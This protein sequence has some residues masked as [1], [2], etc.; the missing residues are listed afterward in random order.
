MAECEVFKKVIDREKYQIGSQLW[1][2]D[3]KYL[4]LM[5]VPLH[6]VD[7]NRDKLYK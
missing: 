5:K 4:P 1:N 7:F 2:V 6:E 3:P